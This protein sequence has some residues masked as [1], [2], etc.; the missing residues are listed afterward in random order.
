M[1]TSDCCHARWL[2]EIA[3]A[4]A[5]TFSLMAACT[6]LDPV[7]EIVIQGSDTMLELNRRLAEEFMRSQ[8]GVAVQVE[9][10]GTGSGVA[11]LLEGRIDLCAA[12]RPFSPDEVAALHDRFATLGV[13]FLV[14]RD[15]LSVYLHPSNPVDDLSMNE[16]RGLFAGSI[17]NWRAVGGRVEAVVPVV[18][19]PSSGTYRF[20]RDHVLRDRGYT[21]GAR[22]AVRTRDVEALVGQLP[23]GVGYG[24]LAFGRDLLHCRIDGVAPTAAT[25]RDGSYPLARYLYF[26][27][28]QPPT[29]RVRDFTDWCIA[30]R[31]QELV[32]AAGFIPL[33]IPPVP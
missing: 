3:A 17:V 31:G 24:G 10:G 20:F 28:A 18:R 16:L 19:P 8:P 15:A 29:G 30:R 7:S 9:G 6:V 2:I 4:A 33:W 14:A 25:V 13:R 26:Y 32:A 23:G 27:A 11:A 12:S 1:R 5:L 22:T 21:A